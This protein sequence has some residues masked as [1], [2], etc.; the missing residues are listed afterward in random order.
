M[1]HDL[2]AMADAASEHANFVYL[3]AAERPW[4]EVFDDEAA[5][6]VKHYI[7]GGVWI[8][9]GG[10]SSTGAVLNALRRKL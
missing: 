7:D 5:V 2:N 10:R 4:N 6:R 9:V 8:T 1:H 3:P